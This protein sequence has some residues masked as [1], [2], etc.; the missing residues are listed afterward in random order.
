MYYDS[1]PDIMTVDEMRNV[2]KIG[3]NKAYSL[4]RNGEIKSLKI[5]GSLRIPKRYLIDFIDSPC[6]NDIVATDGS[7]ESLE[8]LR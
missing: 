6:Y 7:L 5:G 1:I 4:V 8:V 3:R 2:L